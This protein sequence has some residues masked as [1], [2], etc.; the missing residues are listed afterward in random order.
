MPN[1]IKSF[2]DLDCWKSCRDLRVDL[3]KMIKKFPDKEKF[4]LADQIV[5]A[6]RSV[7]NNIA[8]GYGRYHYKENA[9][10][11][12][13]SRGSLFELIDHLI[14]ALEESYITKKEYENVRRLI[15]KSLALLNGYIN[16]LR[17]VVEKD[18]Q[19]TNNS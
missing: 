2:E 18:L 7:T 10:F 12:R 19:L 16:Y 13:Q 17:K 6:S 8:E 1:S 3:S 14:I 15:D 4:L 5:R 9:Q 11:C